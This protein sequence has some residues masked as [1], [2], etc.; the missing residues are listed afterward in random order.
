MGYIKTYILN[1]FYWQYLVLLTMVP[2]NT[3]NTTADTIHTATTTL[4][5]L[6]SFLL[7]LILLLLAQ[8]N[9]TL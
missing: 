9:T 1:H 3:V 2:R 6:P 8:S 4:L 5:V 7:P